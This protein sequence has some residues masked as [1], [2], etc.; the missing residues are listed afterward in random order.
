MDR[1]IVS[2]QNPICA[3]K[4]LLKSNM[5]RFIVSNLHLFVSETDFKIQYGQ[6]YS[7]RILPGVFY[8]NIL[9]SNMD[10]FIEYAYD[11]IMRAHKLLKSNMDRFIGNTKNPVNKPFPF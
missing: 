4:S 10:R 5:D 7:N 9:K 6:I 11:T 2:V 3:Y 1:F 8:Q